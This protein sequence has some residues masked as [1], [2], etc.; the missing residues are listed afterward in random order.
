MEK[1]INTNK[2]FEVVG[3]FFTKKENCVLELLQNAQRSGA[4]SV[5][6]I[7]PYTDKSPFSG[8]DNSQNIL[9]VKDNGEGVTDLLSLLGISCSKWKK[10]IEQ[11]QPAGLGF[12]QLIS[13]SKKVYVKS[14]FGEV[15]IDSEKFTQNADYRKFLAELPLKEDLQYTGTLIIAELKDN[16]LGFI[17]YN[18]IHYQGFEMD[19][20]INNNP[21]NRLDIDTI[22]NE[23]VQDNPKGFIQ[24]SYKGNPLFISIGRG[25]PPSLSYLYGNIVNWYGQYIVCHHS[26]PLN[27]FFYYEVKKN[28]PLTPGYPDREWIIHDNLYDELLAFIKD[29]TLQWCRKK[30]AEY[31]R[32]SDR[33]SYFFQ[34][35]LLFMYEYLPE[36]EAEKLELVPVD[37]EFCEGYNLDDHRLVITKKELLS[38]EY[39]FTDKKLL[40][41][42]EYKLAGLFR[43][44][45]PRAV[46]VNETL[47]PYLERIGLKRIKSIEMQKYDYEQFNVAPIPLV[48]TYSD[49]SC[50]IF[51]LKE[52]LIHNYSQYIICSDSNQRLIEIFD[53]YAHDVAIEGDLPYDEQIS[54]DREYIVSDFEDRY[55]IISRD[56]FCFLPEYFNLITLRFDNDNRQ[57]ILSYKDGREKQITLEAI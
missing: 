29:K 40:L 50:E 49:K 56:K 11:Q 21:L 4:G 6:I 54:H 18:M 53:T 12:L 26:F 14:K 28:T 20:E 13:L 44:K 36:D 24:A 5:K 31:N 34:K 51:I 41:N 47:C 57:V 45:S 16:A 23:M 43:D 33:C 25:R 48:F 39:S 15:I 55:N 8:S 3:R 7:A 22:R 17:H 38:Q 30:Y 1:F 46:A 32:E 35:C 27:L 42:E 37:M 19:I 9:Y 10:E 52:G 2:L